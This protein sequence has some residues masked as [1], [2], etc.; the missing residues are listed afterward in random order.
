MPKNSGI[1]STL[2]FSMS[3]L[4]KKALAPWHQSEYR[5]FFYQLVLLL[6]LFFIGWYL[7]SNTIE[8]LK[9][10]NIATGF[11]FLWS[12]SAF[13]IGEA[14]IPFA[15]SDSYA[16]ALLVG[17]LNT[18]KTAVIGI[19]LTILLGTLMGIARLAKNGLIA[20]LAALY[21]ELFR[22]IPVLLQLF[23]WYA[24]FHQL[25]GPRQAF[26]PFSGVFLCNRGFLFPSPHINSPESLVLLYVPL[27]L[28][29]WWW[30]CRKNRMYR[31]YH[32]KNRIHPS[33]I[34]LVPVLIVI[35]VNTIA[36]ANW[37]IDVP[38]LQGFNVRGGS[39]IT[40]E[41]GA[42]L[43]GLVIYTGTFVAEIVRS[44]ILSVNKGQ[45]EAAKSVGLTNS[46]ILF[47]IVLPQ[48]L[49]VIVPPLTSQMLNLT[50][51]SSLAV[52]VGYPDL[53]SVANTTLNQTGQAIEA[54][55]IVM[56]IYLLFSL[57]TSLFMS[58]FNKQAI[59]ALF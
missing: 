26:K 29:F 23:F 8:N 25:P 28:L 16:R 57:L 34:S 42:L 44:G 36:G 3:S 41:F 14:L 27:A 24:L 2:L 51:N 21:I 20:G 12:E 40:P 38:A 56:L 13:E 22:N 30:L 31:E 5:A 9:R 10:Q 46:K 19:T 59:L 54:I 55:S 11:D 45:V 7:L 37:Q 43:I 52:A 1:D 15:P 32:G 58:W 39:V 6:V 49:R 33:A 47:L 53:F 48:A 50:K 18:L 4:P 17:A 35:G